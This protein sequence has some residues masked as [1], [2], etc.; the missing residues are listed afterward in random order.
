MKIDFQIPIT[1]A[2]A[3]KTPGRMAKK[4]IL[5]KRGVGK[6]LSPFLSSISTNPE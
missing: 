4:K 2:I 1:N 3:K 6:T 5:G